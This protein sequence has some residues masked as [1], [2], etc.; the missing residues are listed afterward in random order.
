MKIKYIIYLP[1]SIVFISC[2]ARKPKDL[3]YLYDNENTGLDNFIYTNGIYTSSDPRAYKQ[4]IVLFNNG[5]ICS[6]D[7]LPTQNNIKLTYPKVMTDKH[8]W[9]IYKV[10]DDIIKTQ[11]VVDLGLDGGIGVSRKFFKILNSKQIK[12]IGYISDHGVY[13]ERNIIYNYEPLEN[14]MDSADCWLLKKKWF[15]TKEAWDN[16]SK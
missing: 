6:P 12:W 5:L 9:G 11:S 1:I 7:V 8:M 4:Y 14:R 10:E 3:T 15:W 13:F 16:R 2:I